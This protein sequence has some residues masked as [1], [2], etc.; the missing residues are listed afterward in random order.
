MKIIKNTRSNEYP[1][2][3]ECV[4]CKSIIELDEVDIKKNPNVKCCDHSG[5]SWIQYD[6]DHPEMTY[7]C[8]VCNRKTIVNKI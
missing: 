7:F 3:C 8:P 6:P 5:M 2:Q 1:W 4:H